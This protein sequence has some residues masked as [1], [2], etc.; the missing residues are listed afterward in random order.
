MENP[1]KPKYLNFVK[2]ITKKKIFVKFLKN[3]R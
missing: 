2:K 1:E 3:Y